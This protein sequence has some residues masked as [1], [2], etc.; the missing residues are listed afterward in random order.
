MT[1]GADQITIID[2]T[3]NVRLLNKKREDLF[4]LLEVNSAAI[5]SSLI[6]I[7]E[8]RIGV[9]VGSIVES[10]GEEYRVCDVIVRAEHDPKGKPWVCGNPKRTDPKRKDFGRWSS[11]V[12]QLFS[13]WELIEK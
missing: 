8:Q 2:L 4:R 5:I 12:K 1:N 7:Y 6:S 3:E 13:D 10:G 11:N 9:K